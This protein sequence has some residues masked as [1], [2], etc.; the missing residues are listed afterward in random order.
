MM[1]VGLLWAGL[2]PLSLALLAWAV[3]RQLVQRLLIN[4]YALPGIHGR[5]GWVL[6]W[7]LVLLPVVLLWWLDWR[8]FDAL[9]S[10]EA[11]ARILQ[12]AKADL[13]FLNSRTANSFGQRYLQD[14]GFAQVEA[15]SIYRRDGFVRYER[16]ASGTVKAT[17]S[18]ALTA[19]Y[20]VRE[21]FSQH[22]GHTG[23][24]RTEVVDRQ[25]GQVMAS[26]GSASFDGGRVKWVLGAWG[27][28]RC[29]SAFSNPQ[30][31]NAHYHLARDTLR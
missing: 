15:P 24:N 29:P 17:E 26:A 8:Q 22:H 9:C 31:F 10:S 2:A 20:E 11:S 14:E 18:D 21:V 25:T 12:R 3:H 7:A 19:R 23:V 30:G 16:D 28:A 5:R 27:S 4:R 6:A 13:I 1:L